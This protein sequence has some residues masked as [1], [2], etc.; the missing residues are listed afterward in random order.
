MVKKLPVEQY[1]NRFDASLLD[2]RSTRELKPLEEIIGQKRALFALTLGL[3]IEE[4]G[5]NVYASG[6]YGTGRKSAVKKFL[7]E[8]ATKKPRGNDWIYVNNFKN[9]YEPNAIRLPTGMGKQF[10][11]DM[12]TFIEEAKR[13][14]PRFSRARITRTAAMQS[15]AVSKTRKPGYSPTS[16]KWPGGRASSSSPG[17]RACSPSP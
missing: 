16:M 9:P 12:A 17:P 13:F 4:R 15:S 3:N 5:F 10:K 7:D 11:E 1:R 14:V 6:M 2:C 8:L